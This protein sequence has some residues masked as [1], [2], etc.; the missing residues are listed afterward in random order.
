MFKDRFK[1]LTLINKIIFFA[2]ICAAAGVLV[3]MFVLLSFAKDLPTREQI[4][5]REITQSTKIYDRT[6]DVL[7]Y[8]ISGG[9][10]RTVVPL[11]EIPDSL[12]EATVILEDENFYTGG[13]VD[14]MGIARAALVNLTSGEVKQ[15]GSTITQQLAKN[16]FLSPER[17]FSRKI[18]EL[19]LAVRL[20]QEYSKDEILE[21]YLNEIPYGPTIY[22]VEA[23]A[24]SYFR[25]SAKDISLAQSAILASIPRAS[26]YY[27]PWGS[28]IE[29]LMTRQQFVLNQMYKAGKISEAELNQALNEK[30]TFEQRPETGLKA[31]H[32]V[33][34]VQEYLANRYGEDVVRG[35]GL[36]VITTLDYELQE[37]A[38]RAVLNGAKRNEKLYGGKNAALVAQDSNTGQIL[39][40]VGSRNYFE[41]GEQGNFN[42]AT[43]GLRQPGSAL[44]P[45]VY[46][47]TFEKGFIPDTVLFDVPT[48]FSGNSACPSTP[49][50]KNSDRRC[51]HPQN[52][53]L[54]FRGPI[55][56]RASLA[57]SINITAVKA[58]YVAGLKNSVSVMNRFG[59]KTLDDPDRYGLSLVLGGGEVRLIDLV[60]AYSVLAEEGVK[61]NQAMVLEVRGPRGN[62]IESFKDKS[63]NVFDPNY[64]RMINDILSDVPARSALF[65]GSIGLTTVAGYDVALKT[66]T[67]NDYMDAWTMGYTP[68]MVIG[69]WAGNNNNTPMHKQGSS[70]LA[71]VPIWGE[72]AEE[73]IRKA[74]PEAFRKPEYSAPDK[75]MLRGEYAPNGQIH[76]ILYWIDKDDPRGPQPSNPSRDPQFEN[77]ELGVLNWANQNPITPP[78]GDIPPPDPGENPPPPPDTG[79]NSNPTVSIGRPSSGSEIDGPIQIFADLRDDSSVSKI[80][81]YFNGSL[82]QEF[83]GDF[84]MSF[85][86]NWS[87]TPLNTNPQNTLQIEVEDDRGATNRS[88]VT[89]MGP[90]ETT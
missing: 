1:N 33:M 58:L 42:A 87:F 16:A 26:T 12:K 28:H 6:G 48:E 53:D 25:K 43:Q 20:D 65:G 80:R 79:P 78:G 38:E 62:L 47:T 32:F 40:M 82:V 39:A 7:L 22:G 21:M 29:D 5:N 45:F 2:L 34:A 11:S 35:G 88:G 49:N 55:N 73:A 15:G 63:E 51:F 67:S 90:Q 44:K 3:F 72:F 66:G 19:L 8:E 76:T 17:T 24:Q 81:V 4:T 9:E 57:N 41:K 52:Y 85:Q 23:A 86:F 37:I 69:V 84:G 59:L 60:G 30:I 89:L 74:Q 14:V 75:P 77:W 27:S 56:I 71:A 18:R 68:N 13:P 36:K 10:K 50:Y 64:V 61:H 46:L 70:I 83:T 31:P 54:K